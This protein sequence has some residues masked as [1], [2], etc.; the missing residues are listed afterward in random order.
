MSRLREKRW[1]ALGADGR[2]VTLGRNS[3]PSDIEISQ[4]EAKL[5]E[6]G[7]GGWLAVAEGD[8]WN[9]RAR[10]T[11]LNVRRLGNPAGAW[12]EA[13][14]AFNQRRQDNLSAA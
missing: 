4:V 12:E 10:M 9:P 2:Y 3:D 1:I 13:V 11:L 14:L 7:L 8:Y 5:N 6:Q